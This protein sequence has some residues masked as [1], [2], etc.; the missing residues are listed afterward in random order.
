MRDQA[1]F[2]K[3]IDFA[4][5]GKILVAGNNKGDVHLWQLPDGIEV[6]KLSLPAG[7][8]LIIPT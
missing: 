3:Q 8:Q 6:G 1:K 5:S 7:K 2:V 4:L